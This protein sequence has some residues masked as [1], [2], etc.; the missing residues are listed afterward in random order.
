MIPLSLISQEEKKDFSHHNL[1]LTSYVSA[2]LQNLDMSFVNTM[3]F[4]G[5]ITNEMNKDWISLGNDE[6][7]KLNSEVRNAI[8]YKYTRKNFNTYYLEIA[9]MNIVNSKFPDDLLRL[10]LEGNY[11]YQNHE[12]D[13]SNTII[14][15]NRYQQYKV[16]YEQYIK[17]NIRLNTA[18]SYLNGNHHISYII[19]EGVL[20]T[21]DMGNEIDIN[22][23]IKSLI[24]DT[25]NISLFNSNGNG[26]AIDIGL[27]YFPN[28]NNMYYLSIKNLGYINWDKNSIISTADSNFLFSG[29]E[30]QD[31]DDI[32]DYNDSINSFDINSIYMS[33]NKR[34]RSFIPTRI[35]FSYNRKIDK[36]YFKNI[37]FLVHSRWQP[38]EMPEKLT[39]EYIEKGIEES[40][41]TPSIDIYTTMETK[42]FL[43]YPGVSKGG[44]TNNMNFHLSISNKKRNITLGTYHLES[45]FNED[46]SSISGYL[47]I[48]SRF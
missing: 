31:L 19:D 9:D 30:A 44:F 26:A 18:I 17:E 45:L 41:Y 28:T 39:F 46:I 32:I 21:H 2:E 13:F 36:K 11:N 42:Y 22:Y 48:T 38:H 4:G 27:S 7:N 1:H 25:S 20:Y 3:I 8:E 23:N 5:F 15:A 12:L 40:G 37:T 10:L 34:F 43:M 29:I 16:G 33:E 24:T 14:R 47:Q 6:I 35:T